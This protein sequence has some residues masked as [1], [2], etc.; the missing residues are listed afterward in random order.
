VAGECAKVLPVLRSQGDALYS[1]YARAP[2]LGAGIDVCGIYGDGA[3]RCAEQRGE[4][5]P[6]G[7]G[8]HQ[9]GVTTT[10]VTYTAPATVPTPAT[11]V[12][13]GTKS[14]V[15]TVKVTAGAGNINV[16]ISPKRGGLTLGQTMSTWSAT[17]SSFRTQSTASS[18]QTP[19]ELSRS[20]SPGQLLEEE[21][22]SVIARIQ[23]ELLLSKWIARRRRFRP[24]WI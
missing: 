8:V 3:E 9:S 13:N 7:S 2:Y 20:R 12:A 11:S 1:Y 4:L 16:S 19:P 22:A 18:R 23:T 5:E 14:A 21:T 17:A 15:A 24:S 10:G 6:D